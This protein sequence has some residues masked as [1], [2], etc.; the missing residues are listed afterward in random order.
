MIAIYLVAFFLFIGLLFNTLGII[1]LIRFPDV[2]TRLHA[3]TKATT[4]GTIFTG[5]AIVV[6]AIY[7][8]L[9]SNESQYLMLIFHVVIAIFALAITNAAGSHAIAKAAMQS[10]YKPVQAVVDRLTDVKIKEKE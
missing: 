3:S 6:F 7:T 9:S 5:L 1:G 4:F 2:Y 10:G 8:F